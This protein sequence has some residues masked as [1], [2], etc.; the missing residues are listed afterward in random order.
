MNKTMVVFNLIYLG[1]ILIGL[2]MFAIVF[3]S[4][5]KSQREKPVSIAAWK[6]RENAWFYVVII[7]LIGALAA[8]IFSTPYNAA[9]QPGRQIVQV[10]AQQFGFVFDKTRIHAGRQVEFDLASKDV[11]HGFGIYD[12]DGVFVAQSQ[13]MPSWPSKLRLTLTKIGTYTVRCFEYC[14]L[15]HHQMITTFEVIR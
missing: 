15:G 7:G 6:R 10:T 9:A 1:A 4:T 13:I 8:T 11:N 3:L 5:R 12:P 14:G 2:A